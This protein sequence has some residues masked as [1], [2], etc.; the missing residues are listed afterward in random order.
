MT[1]APALAPGRTASLLAGRDFLAPTVQRAVESLHLP[2]GAWVLDAGTGSG[3]AL[4]ALARAAGGAGSVRAVDTDPDV[5]PLAAHHAAHHGMGARVSVEHADL[6]DVAG[7]AATARGGGF[8]AI[9]AG[10]VIGPS[11]F[12]DPAAAVAVLT[13]ALRPGG[14]LALFHT[15]DQPVFLPGHAQLERLVRAAA[16]RHRGATP[17]GHN[18]HDR[19]LP[20]L[21]AA[22]LE[23]LTLDVFPRIGLRIET[24]RAARI[25]LDTAV[26]PQM[27][28]SALACGPQVGMTE[29]DLSDL[30]ALTTP[31]GPRYV[32]DDPGYYILHPTVLATGRRGRAGQR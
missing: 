19:H 8:D 20:W 11:A 23:R 28:E 26:W 7:H 6:I 29:N 25:Y 12:A 15:H 14:V 16:E 9:W 3:A 5:L 2:A 32:L 22:G 4:P 24:D 21:Q 1:A 27:W 13:R 30:H 10:D 18:H 31:G 17:D